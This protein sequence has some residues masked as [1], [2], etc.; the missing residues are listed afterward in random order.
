MA[1]YVLRK[2]RGGLFIP[3]LIMQNAAGAKVRLELEP[4]SL[5]QLK[6]A[7]STMAEAAKGIRAAWNQ[8]P[9]QAALFNK[10]NKGI[11]QEGES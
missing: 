9:N 11:E 4:V 3:T 10:L 8:K 6:E 5:I 2:V 7:G 1:R